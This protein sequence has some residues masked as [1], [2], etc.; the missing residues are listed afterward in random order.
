MYYVYFLQSQKDN[1]YYI[2]VTSNPR[3]RLQEHNNGLSKSTRFRKPWVLV[4]TEP[5][6]DI[7]S[8]YRRE[9]FLKAKKSRIIIEKIIES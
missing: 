9:R 3:K 7:K 1:G 2:G 5:Y 4:R 6:E 8:A